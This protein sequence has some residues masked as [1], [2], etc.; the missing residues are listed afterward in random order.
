MR[1]LHKKAD[2]YLKNQKPEDLILEKPTFFP[3]SEIRFFFHKDSSYQSNILFHKFHIDPMFWNR[4]LVIIKMLN[5][6]MIST[7][8]I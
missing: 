1:M 8:F 5:S 7:F 6:P 2:Y 4:D 3:K